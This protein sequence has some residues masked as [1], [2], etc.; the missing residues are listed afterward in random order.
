VV[1]GDDSVDGGTSVAD[2]PDR[3][4]VDSQVENEV[5][6]GGEIL[7]D[8]PNTYLP[9]GGLDVHEVAGGHLLEK[10]VGMSLDDL[11]SRIDDGYSAAS[12]FDSYSSAE[13]FVGEVLDMKK[14]DINDF[15]QSSE[16]KKSFER[17]LV[18][19]PAGNVLTEN[20]DFLSTSRVTVVIVRD[21]NMPNGY[22]IQT[23]FPEL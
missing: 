19:G 16:R 1:R 7:D 6:S 3:K 13:R 20:G 18:S 23:G 10:H 21:G 9:G 17:V 11:Q 14:G 8:M 22:R 12:T 2:T 5:L 15:L 4:G